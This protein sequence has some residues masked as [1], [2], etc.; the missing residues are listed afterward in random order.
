M[1]NDCHAASIGVEVARARAASITPWARIL[2]SLALHGAIPAP[3]VAGSKWHAVALG[4]LGR[5]PE[6]VHFKIPVPR[7]TLS[8]ARGNGPAILRKHS[9]SRAAYAM[10]Y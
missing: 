7:K 8:D 3:T 5:M 9:G 10:D 4:L 6:N 1:I 2:R